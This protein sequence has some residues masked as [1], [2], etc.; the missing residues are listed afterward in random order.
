VAVQAPASSSSAPVPLPVPDLS[1]VPLAMVA[2]AATVASLC[3]PLG[4][5]EPPLVTIL[6][7]DVRTAVTALAQWV[8]ALLDGL[9]RE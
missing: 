7:S 1:L 6:G 2:G 9:R 5:P 3:V 8:A 4:L